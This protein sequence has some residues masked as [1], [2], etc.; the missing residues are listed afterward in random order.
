MVDR[1][2]SKYPHTFTFN[3]IL[4]LIYIFR[5]L[6][7]LNVHIGFSF[8][9]FIEFNIMAFVCLCFLCVKKINRKIIEISFYYLVIQS[10]AS[11]FLLTSFSSIWQQNYFSELTFWVLLLKIGFFPFMWWFYKFSKNLMVIQFFLALSLV[12]TIQKIPL[13]LGSFEALYFFSDSLF[14]LNMLFGSFILVKFSLFLRDFL[15]SSSLY[16]S[17]WLFHI[18]SM[19]SFFFFSFF[20]VYRSLTFFL[21]L[22][23]GP[24]F[25]KEENSILETVLLS[26]MFLGVFSLP[27]ASLFFFKLCFISHILRMGALPI[28]LSWLSILMASVGYIF[29]FSQRLSSSRSSFYHS[30]SG[31]F[32]SLYFFFIFLICSALVFILKSKLFKLPFSYCG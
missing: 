17:F 18:Y 24:Q 11:I 4:W 6:A 28:F 22:K 31:K 13:Y 27:P 29:F 12:L 5:I 32:T 8:W 2:M 19:D 15:V 20:F 23:I 30:Y 26:L 21:S 7:F 25:N 16:S 1:S 10:V 3:R 14:I 9:G